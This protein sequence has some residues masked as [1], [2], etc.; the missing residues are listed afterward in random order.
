MNNA[1]PA[2]I[3]AAII[4]YEKARQNVARLIK[5]RAKLLSKCTN[6]CEKQSYPCLVVAFNDANYEN[7]NQIGEHSYGDT[8]SYN[9][10]LAEG[11]A[12]GRYCD[13]C[14]NAWNI[15]VGTL[16]EAKVE[17]AKAKRAISWIGKALI[18]EDA[19]LI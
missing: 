3:R 12:D 5:D 4:R 11:H 1:T 6:Q 2:Q 18:K 8:Y 16:R 10:I 7:R 15:K 17:F 13:N 14:F 9:D 19:E